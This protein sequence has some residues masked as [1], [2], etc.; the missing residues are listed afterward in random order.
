MHGPG[1]SSFKGTQL[2]LLLVRAVLIMCVTGAVS[3][4]RAQDFN[5][6]LLAA[7]K[8]DYQANRMVQAN[9]ELR[10]AAFGLL[11]RPSLLSEALVRL[12]LAQNALGLT[13]ELTRTL[14]RFIDV[15][16]RFQPYSKVQLEPS[17]R[18]AFEAL[19]LK[20]VPA[21]TL[22]AIPSLSRL[23]ETEDQKLGRMPRADRLKV[24]EAAARREPR[25]SRW[26]LLLAREYGSTEDSRQVILWAGRALEIDDKNPEARALLIHAYLLQS[27]CAEALAI[28][29]KLS[30]GELE[31]RPE[32]YADQAVCYADQKQWKEARASLDKVPEPLR[33]RA[34]VKQATENV[35]K[36]ITPQS[37]VP[38]EPGK[39]APSSQSAGISSQQSPRTLPAK[40]SGSSSPSSQNPTASSAPASRE[41][42]GA[43]PSLQSP[44]VLE[45]TRAMIREN[46]HG[47]AVKL[48]RRSLTLE[49]ESRPL[50][51]ALLE[52]AVLVRDYDTAASEVATVSPL[53][54]GEEL[55]MF[56]A[57]VA[58]YET[59]KKD[60]ARRLMQKARP[61][62]V[63]SP[64][65][66]SYV[67]AILGPDK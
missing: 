55:Y 62:M 22:T 38:K 25:E 39:V 4:G 6:Q 57:A 13:S 60:D 54:S 8:L 46:R 3:S 40:G 34:D 42:A 10:I 37:A 12:S 53:G 51:L 61:H 18:S 35:T 44:R 47:D 1:P 21:A 17:I 28:L 30:A 36:A 9:D 24:L 11:D 31:R 64:F 23:I 15:E 65:V 32:L 5:E 33:S 14:D 7:G 63:R 16:Q 66:D 50:H 52:A 48:L 29:G 27:E 2:R 26:P 59:G 19:L 20:S 45:E 41:A 43:G 58:M 67:R 49:P 56:H